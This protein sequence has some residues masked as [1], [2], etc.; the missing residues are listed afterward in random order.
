[1]RKHKK[2]KAPPVYDN[3]ITEIFAEIDALIKI[4]TETEYS[5]VYGFAP[6]GW[7]NIGRFKRRLKK[8]RME[9]TGEK[10]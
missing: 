6:Q 8:L 5:S 9:Y 2:K 4:C 7:F 1:M 10:K 3:V